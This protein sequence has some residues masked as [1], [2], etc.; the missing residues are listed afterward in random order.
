MRGRSG[1]RGV[2]AV[3]FALFLVAILSSAS[4]AVDLGSARQLDR[5]V[6][7][8]ADAS[9]LAAA[10]ELPLRLDGTDAGIARAEA[11]AYAARNLHGPSAVATP[12]PCPVGAGDVALNT[13]CFTSGPSSIVVE[14]PYAVGGQP[15]AARHFIAVS[16]CEDTPTW[17]AATIGLRSPRICE[18]AVAR[19]YQAALSYGR[20]LVTVDPQA[21]PGLTVDGAAEVRIV[22]E[23]GVFVDATCEGS[24]TAAGSAWTL[25]AATLSTAGALQVSC[26]PSKCMPTLP[27]PLTGQPP[28]GDPLQGLPE[29][30]EP[31]EPAA[32]ASC[33]QTATEEVTCTPGRYPTGGAHR[34]GSS[35]TK[36]LV[37]SPG[38]HWF[39]DGVDFGNLHVRVAE[40]TDPETGAGVLVFSDAGPVD[41]GG[42]GRVEL[43]TGPT[44]GTWKGVGVYSGRGNA[45]LVK[46]TGNTGMA[47]G[48]I[49]VPD[50]P[51]EIGGSSRWDIT[52]MVVAARTRLFGKMDLHIDP[53]EPASAAPPVE[54]L[55][56]ER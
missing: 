47:I 38:I 17:F 41:V 3:L 29:P 24:V 52:G 22:S 25:A 43:G 9:A 15:L 10:Q 26:D 28:I 8:A 50:G 6:Q 37:L 2:A 51:L 44:A 49:Y 23:G 16:I 18:R 7:S 56:L 31:P 27:P 40:G 13:A 12:V 4:L 54:D 55:G 30:P 53:Q 20:G 21:C 36:R 14:T 1:E 33:V 35:S 46:I 39:P 48:S 34:F 11:A 42:N 32:A 45:S 19:R 5:R